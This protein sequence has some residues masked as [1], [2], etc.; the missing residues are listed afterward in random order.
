V[1]RNGDGTALAVE[2]GMTSGERCTLISVLM[3]TDLDGTSLDLKQ[4]DRA[5]A[6]AVAS[7]VLHFAANGSLWLLVTST[8]P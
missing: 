1:H 7:F 5:K 8:R 2:I 6:D 3:P 4:T